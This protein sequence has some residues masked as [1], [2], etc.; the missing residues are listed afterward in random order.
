MQLPPTTFCG[1]AKKARVDLSLF[2]RL[3][4]GR[5]PYTMLNTQYRMPACVREFASNQFYKGRLQDGA[6]I[7]SRERPVGV[8]D[9]P[10]VFFDL[11]ES[12]QI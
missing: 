5:R 7:S 6:N 1:Q 11:P 9:Q 12:C 8:P 2:E 3:L 10:L 4:E